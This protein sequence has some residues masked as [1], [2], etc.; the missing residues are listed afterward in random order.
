MFLQ[1][2][3]KSMS[4]DLGL[5]AIEVIF[6]SGSAIGVPSTSIFVASPTSLVEN[7]NTEIKNV[8]EGMRYV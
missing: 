5:I 6:L 2:G 3:V 7:V 4:E 1:N 8:A